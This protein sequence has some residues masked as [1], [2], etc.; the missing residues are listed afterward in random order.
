MHRLEQNFD[1]AM[2]KI[3]AHDHGDDITLDAAHDDCKPTQHYNTIQSAHC[4]NNRDQIAAAPLLRMK[5]WT[6]NDVKLLNDESEG[7]LRSV[8][9]SHLTS[10]RP[11]V[12]LVYPLPLLHQG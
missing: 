4:T 7:S 1:D 11:F 9:R 3:Q 5:V 12:F 8:L 10:L 6:P 2:T